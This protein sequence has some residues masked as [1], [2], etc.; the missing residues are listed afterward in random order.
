M[1]KNSAVYIVTTSL[2]AKAF[3]P[4]LFPTLRA[5]G[6]DPIVICHEPDELKRG[7]LQEY[8]QVSVHHIPMVREISVSRDLRSLY[9]LWRLLVKLKPRIVNSGTPKA[10]L[11]GG[12][13]AFLAG[14]P[15]RVYT[16][17]G[18]RLETLLGKRK[19]L[20]TLTEMLASR[21]AHKVVCVSE[22]LKVEA[23]R[24]KLFPQEKG[25]VLGG[26]S[27]NGVDVYNLESR[28]GTRNLQF[29]H[30]SSLESQT[31]GFIGRF[32][33]DK[34]VKELVE[35]FRVISFQKPNARL[36]LLG[37]FE[38][39]DPVDSITEQFIRTDPR[40][41][42]PGFVDDVMPFLKTMTVLALPT[43]REGFP[44]TVLEAA[45]SKVAVVTT[46]ATGARDAI[47]NG[48]TGLQVRSGDIDGLGEKI[49]LLLNDSNLRTKLVEENYSRAVNEFSQDIVWNNWIELYKMNI[50]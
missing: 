14:V 19:I 38:E 17:H 47:I 10:G 36:L 12:L 11:L 16:L 37:D 21:V 41:I 43:Y 49:L 39:G 27:I 26:G 46:Y 25:V 30:L 28:T 1:R 8:L 40:I 31:I 35:A 34:G 13:A 22:S 50:R 20:L 9:L 4:G 15:F 2:S 45:V 42:W 44:L 24:L 3:F 29:E 33:R 6:I 5:A 7:E 23:V 32:T 18:L 48:K